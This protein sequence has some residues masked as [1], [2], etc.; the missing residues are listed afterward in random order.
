[1][2]EL[3]NVY[4]FVVQ[5]MMLRSLLKVS[6][7]TMAKLDY[8]GKPNVHEL[9]VA[10]DLV[11][12]LT[13]FEWAT[14]LTQGENKVTA[15]VILPVV[16]G[17][18][19]EINNLQQKYKSRFVATLKSSIDT[20]LAK[21]EQES[22]KIAAALDPRWKLAWCT[23]EESREI[24]QLIIEKVTALCSSYPSALCVNLSDSPPPK[25]S[26]LFQFMSAT[27]IE[28]ITP[29]EGNDAMIS[30]VEKYFNSPCLPEDTEPLV[31]WK[32]HQ[33]QQ[34]QMAHLACH[35]L[36]IPASS[37]PVE[38]LFSVAGKVFRPDR[39]RLSD[40]LFEKLMFIK[41]NT[42]I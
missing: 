23:A 4:F 25:R 13:P 33:C 41:C 10:K 9:N 6:E 15:S 11:E 29:T 22:F 18:R 42:C 16:R 7:D 40:T 17:L 20:W 24:K 3:G 36:H 37:A 32:I 35:Y 38:H 19:N 5:L 28:R 21:Y 39:C 31:F 1:M 14:D 34:P 2:R 8:N 12:I 26:K 27:P 30:Q